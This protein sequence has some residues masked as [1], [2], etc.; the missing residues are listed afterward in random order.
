VTGREGEDAVFITYDQYRVG[1]RVGADVRDVCAV[2]H[3]ADRRHTID[4]VRDCMCAAL[5]GWREPDRRKDLLDAG[6]VVPSKLH[7]P[8][9]RPVNVFGAPVN[10]RSHQ[11][12]LGEVRSPAAGTVRELGLFVK[13][14][15]SVCGPADQIELPDLPGREFHYEGE[16]AVVVARPVDLA[17]PAEALDAIGGFT[18]AMDLTLRLESDHREERSMRKSFKT[19]TPL[20]PGIRPYDGVSDVSGLAMQ[21]TVNGELKQRGVLGDLIAGIGEL[22]ALAS[23]IVPLEPGDIVLTGTPSGVGPIA[24][25]DRVEVAVDGL[26]PLSL[27]VAG[28]RRPGQEGAA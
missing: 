8:I 10:Y 20:G 5:R 17:T 12:E 26:P 19:F 14:T 25:G 6:L 23:S 18:A 15:G 2:L 1:V 16:V 28:R 7:A 11:G 9:P 13:T 21:L 24:V 27:K 3:A 4:D 22:V